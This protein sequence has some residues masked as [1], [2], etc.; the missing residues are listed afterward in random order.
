MARKPSVWYRQQDGWFY[1]TVAGEQIKLS[2]DRDEAE[3]EFH[4]VLAAKK[5]H[6][7][8]T[9]VRVSFRKLVDEFL[10]WS[11]T[12]TADYTFVW[13]RRTLQ[14]LVDF[15]GKK[16]KAADLTVRQVER[17]VESKDSWGHNTRVKCR[18]TVLICLNWGVKRQ[19]LKE[20]PVKT[21]DM[22]SYHSSERILS[23]DERERIRGA[24]RG[25]EF[26]DYLRVV[27]L[28]GARPFSEIAAIT[29]EMIDFD[30]GV[31]E[32]KRHKNARKGKKRTVY[33]TPELTEIL[34]RRAAHRPTGV[35]FRSMQGMPI[36][37]RSVSHRMRGVARRL[38][39]KPLTVYAY[40]HTYITE[41]LER[42]LTAS[43][44]AQL[45]GN[46]PKTIEKYYDHLDQRKSALK[47]AAR[48][49]VG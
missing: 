3:R 30:A 42:G 35:L 37:S 38:G 9:L 6:K 33:L 7:E 24:V 1:T 49:A 14:S 25:Q 22:G 16:Q 26:R 29:A 11:K 4:A 5:T 10:E 43:V 32:L 39:I 18:A 45:V 34:R 44:V 28:T 21:L 41:S 46:S 31:I 12:N 40:R 27:E 2:Q 8:P 13:R 20:N 47:E 36:D 17:W 15:V 48:R 19:L 23:R